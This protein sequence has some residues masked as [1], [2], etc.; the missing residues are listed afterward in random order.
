MRSALPWMKLTRAGVPS[1]VFGAGLA[2]SNRNN[3]LSIIGSKQETDKDIN[4]SRLLGSKLNESTTGDG[5]SWTVPYFSLNFSPN[6]TLSRS[7]CRAQ[8]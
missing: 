7:A 3:R 4:F 5:S 6:T 8:V 1:S 2:D